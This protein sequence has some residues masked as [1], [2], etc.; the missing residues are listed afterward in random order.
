MDTAP[1]LCCRLLRPNKATHCAA[2]A[3]QQPLPANLFDCVFHINIFRGVQGLENKTKPWVVPPEECRVEREREKAATFSQ[4]N[5]L[6]CSLEKLIHAILYCVGPKNTK[7]LISVGW[8]VKSEYQENTDK[9]I[10]IFMK[11]NCKFKTSNYNAYN[12]Y[13]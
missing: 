1:W 4:L 12:L 5:L 11:S 3:P 6:I 2:N 7:L 9:E 8:D 13:T 10:I